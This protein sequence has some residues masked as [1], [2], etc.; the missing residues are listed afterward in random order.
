MSITQM[1]GIMRDRHILYWMVLLYEAFSKVK[2][3][4]TLG[5]PKKWVQNKSQG[6]WQGYSKYVEYNIITMDIVASI[7]TY[8]CMVEVGV[9]LLFP[10]NHQS[11]YTPKM[12]I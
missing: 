3:C 5:V 4:G 10:G 2:Q 1:V 12:N 7:F 8:I 11:E 9:L 6:V